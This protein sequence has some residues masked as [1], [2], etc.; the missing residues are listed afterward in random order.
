MKTVEIEDTVD[1][2]LAS[3]DKDIGHIQKSLSNLDELRS[4]VI[5]RDDASLSR[6][7]ERIRSEA[8][9]FREHELKRQS[10]RQ[11][12]AN[13]LGCSVKNLTLSM[14]EASTTDDKKDRINRTRL[15]L[16]A[17]VQRLKKEYASTAALL[18]D[19]ARF[20]NMLLRSIFGLGRAG[21][22]F[23]NAHG[24]TKRHSVTSF[25]NLQF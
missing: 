1:E 5:K 14:L 11:K 6:L 7:L 9:G 25:V 2:L 17:L 3:L 16:R 4:L 8:D 23:Y 24:A 12:L 15:T 19:C 22:V 10:L 13:A 20:N 21:E 18:S